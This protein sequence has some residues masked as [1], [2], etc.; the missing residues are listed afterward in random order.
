[1]TNTKE[2]KMEGVKTY[3]VGSDVYDIPESDVKE[4]LS[5][6]SDA[7][8][9]ESFVVENDTFDIPL[10]EVNDFLKEYPNATSL[11]KKLST[12]KS[13]NGGT[14]GG[15]EVQFTENDTFTPKHVGQTEIEGEAVDVFQTPKVEVK[16]SPF[17]EELKAVFKTIDT[18][19]IMMANEIK[20]QK[21]SPTPQDLDG[22]QDKFGLSL[23][24]RN[25]IEQYLKTGLKGDKTID[26]TFIDYVGYAWDR[27]VNNARLSSF[28]NMGRMPTKEEL[29]TIAEINRFETPV[30]SITQRFN[31][32]PDAKAGFDLLAE[33]E[34]GDFALW[35]A[36][37]VVQSFGSLYKGFPK[38]ADRIIQGA[39]MGGAT[40]T[41]VPGI[42]TG[43]G[44]LTG[45]GYGYI[46][47]M[48][49][50]SANLEYANTF[51]GELQDS[52][53]DIKSAE[54]LESAFNDEELIKLAKQKALLKGVPVGFFDGLAAG[55]GG[56]LV[57]SPSNTMF[58][59]LRNTLIETGTQGALGGAGAA[60]G[61]LASEGEITDGKEIMTEI[62]AEFGTS[63]VEILTGSARR[64]ATKKDKAA[65]TASKNKKQLFKIFKD[66]TDEEIEFELE[67]QV[68]LGNLKEEKKEL[69]FDL[70]K[71]MIDA[72][73]EVPNDV[74]NKEDAVVLLA[75]KKEKEKQKETANEVFNEVIDE[76]ISEL[77]TSIKELV[78]KQEGESETP[79]AESEQVETQVEAKKPI[80]EMK[81][82]SVTVNF[83]GKAISG[84]V[85]V[86]EG[87]KAQI[88]SGNQIFDLPDDVEYS[89]YVSPIRLADNI[90]GIEV[91]G[92]VYAEVRF[93]V[94]DNQEVALLIKEDGT[95]LTMREPA[96]V[97]ELKYQSAL[98]LM[99][100]TSE[101]QLNQIYN[102]YESERKTTQTTEEEI[103]ETNGT[104]STKAEQDIR[105]QEAI[106]EINLIE[107]IALEQIEQAEGSSKLVQHKPKSSKDAKVYLVTKN[108]DG[109]Y[110]ATLD[111][112]KVVNK[113][114]LSEI[115]KK[116]EVTTKQD[117]N[118]LIP[119]LQEQINNLKQEAENK[120]FGIAPA[121]EAETVTKTPETEPQT[122]TTDKP[123]EQKTDDAQLT[124]EEKER[125]QL[126]DN[127]KEADGNQD[128]KFTSKGGNKVVDESGNPLTLYHASQNTI[129]AP[130]FLVFD[131][132]KLGTSTGA[133]S[134]KEGFFFT[135][136]KENA[137]KYLDESMGIMMMNL[138]EKTSLF[139]EIS[140]HN[141]NIKNKGQKTLE[142]IK[143]LQ[144]IPDTKRDEIKSI[145]ADLEIL[146]KESRE[147]S[148]KWQ[149]DF[150]K[151]IEKSDIEWKKHE[152]ER[153]KYFNKHKE[154]N[155][156]LEEATKEI[157]K[158]VLSLVELS[159]DNLQ[160][161]ID[162]YSGVFQNKATKRTGIYSVNLRMKN[163][164]IVNQK[165]AEYRD[166]S[167]KDIIA[168]AKKNN[169]DG[170]IIKNTKDP[171]LTDIYVVFEPE[172]IRILTDENKREQLADNVKKAEGE[173]KQSIKDTFGDK[174][175]IIFDPFS[176]AKADIKLLNNLKKYVEAKLLLGAYDLKALIQD[177][178]KLGIEIGKDAE[179]KW[180]DW[181]NDIRKK[182]VKN[183]IEKET[184]VKKKQPSEQKRI[185]KS[186]TLG[187]ADTKKE[188]EA[189]IA[190]LRSDFEEFYASLKQKQKNKDAELAGMKKEITNLIT[191]ALKKNFITQRTFNTIIK[192]LGNARTL[193]QHMKLFEYIEQ[194][195]E[196]A[197]YAEQMQ[198][199]RNQQAAAKK[200]NHVSFTKMVKEFTSINPENI[201]GELLWEYRK[202]LDELSG[203]IPSYDTM[204][205]TYNRV[206]SKKKGESP[207]DEANT[208][209]KAMELYDKIG[210]N[211]IDTLEDYVAL[212]KDINAF[213]RKI[214]Q[215]IENE[216]NPSVIE[217][218]RSLLVKIGTEQADI[219]SRYANRINALKEEF[220]QELKERTD[221]IDTK[222][223][224]D[225]EA[226]L[227]ERLLQLTKSRIKSLSPEKIFELQSIADNIIND[228]IVDVFRLNPLLIE[229]EKKMEAEEVAIQINKAEKFLDAF[230]DKFEAVKK[231]GATYSTF[232]E[233]T[234]GLNSIRFGAF[235]NNIA[236]PMERAVAAYRR[237]IKK[238]L[239]DY[240][241]IKKKHRIKDD[242]LVKL[243][244]ISVYLREY[245]MNFNEELAGKK[246]ADGNTFGT[247]DWFEN[248]EQ[249]DDY[250]KKERNEIKK[251][252]D[253]L[254]KKD[255]K[256]DIADVY[257]S[258]IKGD[259]KYLSKAEIAFLNEVNDWKA[260]N[261][262]GKQKYA[263]EL[264]GKPFT[265]E[266]LHIMRIRKGRGIIADQIEIND[267]SNN[268]RIA[269]GT[270]NEVT[271]HNIGAI[272]TNFEKIFTANVEQTERDYNITPML[273]ELSYILNE[274]E[275]SVSKDNKPY[276][277]TARE[278]L[279]EALN[280]EFNMPDSSVFSR[281]ARRLTKAQ[282]AK[283]LIAIPR[284]GIE[285][286]SSLIAYPLRS[287][288]LTSAVELFRKRDAV[289]LLMDYTQSPFLNVADIS[290]HL[291]V[292]D[293]RVSDNDITTKLI[294]IFA[295]MPER[296]GLEPIW[297]ASF[298]SEFEHITG[299]SFDRNKAVT[300]KSYL[301]TNKKAIME[302]AAFADA[303]YQ[304]IA[305]STTQ[306]GS[307]RTAL[308]S[309]MVTRALGLDE[310][311]TE[312][313]GGSTITFF[314]NYPFR[315]T[316]QMIKAAKG[317]S[318]AT[319]ST[320][321]DSVDA[322][323]QLMPIL[324]SYV[325]AL[326]YQFGQAAW[327]N[328]KRMLLGTDKEKEEAEKELER[329]KT[330]KGVL[331]ESLAAVS[332]VASS[333][334]GAL[335]RASLQL[336]G[337]IAFN[338]A[339]G[340]DTKAMAKA[341]TRELTFRNPLEIKKKKD[342]SINTY[343]LPQEIAHEVIRYIPAL[344][345]LTENTAN[346]IE[347]LGGVEYLYDKVSKGEILDD[348]ERDA[349]MSLQVLT[350]IGNV[351]VMGMGGAIPGTTEINKIIRTNTKGKNEKDKSEKKGERIVNSG[352]KVMK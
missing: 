346:A 151:G 84:I 208:F 184:G 20:K 53:V 140:E 243:G 182:A 235:T 90:D 226:K 317:F 166:E 315:E 66:L 162:K 271:N 123:Q 307:R 22:I 104:A 201:K 284:T 189:K 187:K 248:I 299:K 266:M 158:D 351:I 107:L 185:D 152:T 327:Y 145:V 325:G 181:L 106:E 70:I 147:H 260:T 65:Y 34:A 244:M 44:A 203:K 26:P 126:A 40:G 67:R 156:K 295:A 209:E 39:S 129:D 7:I 267:K 287:G 79:I 83:G 81:G 174:Q 342:G 160:K 316:E 63:P 18:E 58:K 97:E 36:E 205:K 308:P 9:V 180:N 272:E 54:S 55:L 343:G 68:A 15:S 143:K 134:A 274:S 149:Q 3:K 329:M 195:V 237:S 197:N 245:G 115:G 75:E 348:A 257:Q 333:R 135:K 139:Q 239:T 175:G 108:A 110:S 289:R 112:K 206:M 150:E 290:K 341:I 249:Y 85:E 111:G 261:I 310:I 128:I 345:V 43:A 72:D 323:K 8:E 288:Q 332:S 98:A 227:V 252:W 247:R 157:D 336:L 51:I 87:G 2:N 282:V 230:K 190:E 45:G 1:L 101:Q 171:L 130:D 328:T 170:V 142:S 28:I 309:N 339:E 221:M 42:G 99:E 32:A 16:E 300:D 218:Y 304:Q 270:G 335:S 154:L 64:L 241:A 337:T 338:V 214:N 255:G 347:S 176:N 21:R 220:I 194:T 192:R 186:Y 330:L 253:S 74:P 17:T 263:N 163:P 80:A 169:N 57:T 100:G 146:I 121:T 283:S 298:A 250:T 82:E 232:W 233:S 31:E 59:K 136:D 225:E 25:A 236:V 200:R 291:D 306:A 313:I 164:L 117:V 210:L 10:N 47:G 148:D 294:D 321:H 122:T 256:V 286:L 62:I 89:E 324:G 198:E 216:T 293:G 38:V 258:F 280:K 94:K 251:V 33:A 302:S 212:F 331:T 50:Q 77:E 124:Q 349:L 56:K 19:A 165:N 234:L 5:N 159:K 319:K 297:M 12:K 144:S 254:T 199:V 27:G 178:A 320:E 228:G 133:A 6:F 73:K 269:A 350:N 91:N 60:A 352:A 46:Y 215:L 340:D 92:E 93:E 113:N 69:M 14:V 204:L 137:K 41:V 242:Q 231:L 305:G 262:T 334:Y 131:K 264:R 86:D 61:Q 229:A 179:G 29:K 240:Q 311:K 88:Q 95:L 265:E 11:K 211:K 196:N 223:L 191:S 193:G 102:I 224:N 119:K 312:S 141:V 279:R 238:A 318:Q 301:T 188:Y 326:T 276:V 109:S 207:F 273:Q 127:I 222:G 116:Y 278:N 37:T 155:K 125:E 168:R 120:L 13:K 281:I 23:E 275:K 277:S 71:S 49:E 105:L 296:V 217:D 103:S 96:I 314:T 167:Y 4:F 48:G 173:L 24:Q 322:F 132:S 76:D 153:A 213:K 202:A 285:L 52:G 35:L 177:M 172:Q 303:T 30:S 268:I 78:K 118:S 292:Q 114:V 219:E 161:I 246:D 183:Q 138:P 259:T 344:A